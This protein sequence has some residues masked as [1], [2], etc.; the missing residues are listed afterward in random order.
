MTGGSPSMGIPSALLGKSHSRVHLV[1][2]QSLFKQDVKLETRWRSLPSSVSMVL[3]S[4]LWMPPKE[5]DCNEMTP[6][7]RFLKGSDFQLNS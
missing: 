5:T 3:G 2:V 7:V 6:S 4:F 1:C